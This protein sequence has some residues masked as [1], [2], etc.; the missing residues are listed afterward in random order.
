[1]KLYIRVVSY[2]EVDVAIDKPEDMKYEDVEQLA[3]GIIKAD[4]G[5]D[6]VSYVE[7][8]AFNSPADFVSA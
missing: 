7:E 4:P 6:V 3:D 5:A 2:V 8:W 1:M